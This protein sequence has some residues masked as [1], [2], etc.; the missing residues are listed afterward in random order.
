MP[1]DR[2]VIQAWIAR[3]V[4]QTCC[5]ATLEVGR[6]VNK[7]SD[8]RIHQRTSAHHTRLECDNERAIIQPPLAESLCGVAKRQQFGVR[9]WILQ[10]LA[11]VKSC[12]DYDTVAHDNSADRNL[13]DIGRMRCERERELHRRAVVVD[14]NT[15]NL[16]LTIHGGGG[17]IRTHGD[18]RLTRFPSVPIRPLSHPSKVCESLMMRRIEATAERRKPVERY[19]ERLLYE[20]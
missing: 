8:A 11:F 2:R 17:G 19:R 1:H 16:R 15:E 20:A 5:R 10:R 14:L 9:G 6:A 3:H 12:G 18:L 7:C 4:V 13:A